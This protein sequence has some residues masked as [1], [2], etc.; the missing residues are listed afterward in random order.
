MGDV[1]LTSETKQATHHSRE[2]SKVSSEQKVPRSFAFK[3]FLPPSITPY[4]IKT[5]QLQ[6]GTP[7]DVQKLHERITFDEPPQLPTRKQPTSETLNP[8]LRTIQSESRSEYD[9]VK[10]VHR[11]QKKAEKERKAQLLKERKERAKEEERMRLDSERDGGD[12]NLGLSLKTDG[13]SSQLLSLG[14]SGKGKSGSGSGKDSLSF[15]DAMGIKS[16]VKL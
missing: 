1:K 9:R 5:L 16:K 2:E 7:S 8:T 12:T 10:G 14:D 6:K 11:E 3:N 15:S 13:I 4:G